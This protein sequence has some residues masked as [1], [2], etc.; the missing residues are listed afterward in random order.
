MSVEDFKENFK[1]YS[2]VMMKENW[3][4]TFVEK[5]NAVN[6]KTYKFNFAISTEHVSPSQAIVSKRPPSANNVMLFEDVGD[7]GENEE[8]DD[9]DDDNQTSFDTDNEDQEDE[10]EDSKDDDHFE[11]LAQGEGEG[12]VLPKSQA[13]IDID[14]D[15]DK[16]G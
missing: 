3:K 5:R 1:S 11:S 7:D 4:Q 15:A 9:E 12:K 10:Q 14:Q 16:Q 2:I 8:E 13:N 6:K